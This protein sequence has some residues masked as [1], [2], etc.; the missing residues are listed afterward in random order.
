MKL[1]WYIIIY[2]NI[3]YIISC[4]KQFIKNNKLILKTQQKFKRKRHVFTEWI[5]KIPLSSN[6]HKRIQSIDSIKYVY[7]A[8]KDFV[9]EK[10]RWKYNNI[11][12]QYE[13]D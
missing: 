3:W 11:I 10:K 6:D 12:K 5:N 9:S 8:K 1:T 2:H 4:H 7:R 13:N